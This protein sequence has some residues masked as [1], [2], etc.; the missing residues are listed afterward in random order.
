M[1][2]LKNKKTFYEEKAKKIEGRTPK[3][4]REK[5]NKIVVKINFL[6][7]QLGNQI[8]PSAYLNIL[9]NQLIHD[10]SLYQYFIQTKNNN[11]ASL[12][13]P[14]IEI[15]EKEIQELKKFINQK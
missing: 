11:N 10:K 15:L 6:Q 9:E 5:I 13:K 1:E 3:E 7:N 8:Q 14:R 12:V 2:V 4:L